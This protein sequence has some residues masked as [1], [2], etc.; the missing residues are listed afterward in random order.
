METINENQEVKTTSKHYRDT[1]EES[2]AKMKL[3]FANALVPEIF[4]VMETVGYTAD[5]ISFMSNKVTTLET[6]M[7]VKTKELADQSKEQQNFELKREDIN[8]TYVKH[9]ALSRIVFKD[10]VHARVSLSLDGNTPRAFNAW[11]Q[12]ITNFYA[13]LGSQPALL[14]KA[15][16]VGITAK[17]VT[18]QKQAINELQTIK[19]NLK[20]ETAEAQA[21]TDTRDRAFDE[22]YPLYSEYIKYAK[23]LLN[24]NQLLEAIGVKVKAK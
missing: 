3:T 22:I 14:T 16:T 10:D 9:L 6:L 13:Q 23:I 19:E 18:D 1:M 8:T 15:T 2:L 5:K 21:A 7:Q 24:N 4:S 11:V 12:S 20:E 17:A